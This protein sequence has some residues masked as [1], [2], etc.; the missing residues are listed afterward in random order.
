MIHALEFGWPQ[1]L[2]WSL[3]LFMY[4]VVGIDTYVLA[5]QKLCVKNKIV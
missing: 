2:D 3:F 5:Q 4:M 1:L